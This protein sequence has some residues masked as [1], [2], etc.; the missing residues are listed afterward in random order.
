MLSHEV[1]N[2]I[3]LEIRDS[4]PENQYN[5]DNRIINDRNSPSIEVSKNDH[6]RLNSQHDDNENQNKDAQKRRD[7]QILV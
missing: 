7:L 6:E 5:L 1:N 2:N 3:W 4:Q